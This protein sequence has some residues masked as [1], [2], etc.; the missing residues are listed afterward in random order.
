MNEANIQRCTAN[1]NNKL[2]ELSDDCEK[3]SLRPHGKHN[4]GKRVRAN[5]LGA[6]EIEGLSVQR[7]EHSGG[8]GFLERFLSTL[9]FRRSAGSEGTGET[10]AKE[11][12]VL[13]E[14]EETITR[15]ATLH[16]KVAA[17]QK[18]YSIPSDSLL[19][20]KDDEDSVDYLRIGVFRA[21][22]LESDH[23]DFLVDIV[24]YAFT[25]QAHYPPTTKADWRPLGGHRTFTL[26]NLFLIEVFYSERLATEVLPLAAYLVAVTVSKCSLRRDQLED[27]GIAAVRLASKIESQYILSG[28]ILDEFDSRK[29]DKMERAI[30][31][32][33]DFELLRCS[34]LFFMRILQKLAERHPWQW[35]FAKFCSQLANC[36]MEL[37]M[38]KPCLLAGVVMR[39]CC[40]LVSDNEWPEECYSVVGEPVS[41]YDEPHAILCRL[42]LTARVEDDFAE[43]YVR[44]HHV[45]EHALS[46]RPGWMEE[47]SALAN[48]VKMVGDRTFNK[49]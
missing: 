32:S 35:K 45:V 12:N 30:C 38:V 16:I 6:T 13:P 47:Q 28:D 18:E 40:L 14:P 5:T 48:G 41:D 9:G 37:A 15:W 49:N 43:A 26:T 22:D 17:D 25:K 21:I 10:I 11:D 27:L 29:L 24:K 8:V 19:E 1:Y 42:I 3:L 20:E 36:Q 34:A 23:R 31:R 7:H 2:K 44:Y 33:T 46:L 4:H 39:L